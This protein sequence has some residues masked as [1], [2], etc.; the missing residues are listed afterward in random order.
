[1]YDFLLELR[2]KENRRTVSVA[3]PPPSPFSH[4]R[5]V[6]QVIHDLSIVR[7]EHG[8]GKPGQIHPLIMSGRYSTYKIA[9]TL[10][11]IKSIAARQ[12]AP[13]PRRDG[14]QARR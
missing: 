10:G 3:S 4:S 1:M 6:S 5:Y 14:Y 13:E 2:H 8:K 9:H 12:G 11:V 7:E